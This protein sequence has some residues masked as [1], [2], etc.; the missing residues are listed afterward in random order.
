MPHWGIPTWMFFHTLLAKINP[1]KYDI[2]KIELLQYITS[3]CNILP[4][5]TCRE[6]ASNYIKKIKIQQLPTLDSFKRMIFDFHN[7]VNVRLKK[8]IYTYDYLSVYDHLNFTV[9]FNAFV[10]EFTKSF[11][12]TRYISD[13][14]FRQR[15]VVEIK[16]WI[17]KNKDCFL[18]L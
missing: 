17:L 9:I 7:H 8:K 11:H 1:D 10:K 6:H 16:H 12:D 13:I 18:L 15:K 14:M 2:I 4:C 3:I 5:P